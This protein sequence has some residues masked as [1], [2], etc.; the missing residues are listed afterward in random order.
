MTAAIVVVIN[1]YI[2][3]QRASMTYFTFSLELCSGVSCIL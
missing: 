2:F 1:D 3:L